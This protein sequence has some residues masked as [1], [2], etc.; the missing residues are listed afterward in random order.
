KLQDREPG[1]YEMEV[2]RGERLEVV[3][4]SLEI[5]N[6][7]A[8]LPW[9]FIYLGCSLS[10]F[11]VGMMMALARPESRMIQWG[12]AGCFLTAALMLG[13]ALH[14]LGGIRH[15]FTVMALES[16]FPLFYIAGYLFFDSF[17]EPVSGSSRWKM[18]F[19]AVAGLGIALWVPRTT[20]N[21]LRAMGPQ[22]AMEFLDRHWKLLHFYYAALEPAEVLYAAGAALTILAVL[23][24]NYVLLP[25]GSGRRRIR[26]VVWSN[27]LALAPVMLGGVAK[28]VGYL[29]AA[30]GDTAAALDLTA[31]LANGFTI[32]APIGLGYAVLKHRILGFG[33]VLR[34]GLSYMLARNVLRAMLLLPLA[35]IAFTV[36]TNPD[37]TLG[38]LLFNGWSRLNL[39][40]L[41]AGALG[42]RYGTTLSTAIDKRFFR[43]AYDQQQ[44]LL[45]LI[46]AIQQ[47][48][49]LAQIAEMAASQIDAALHVP[50]VTVLYRSPE[51]QGF[52]VS[53]SS[54]NEARPLRLEESSPM[55][56]E[57]RQSPAART[58]KELA[59]VSTPDETAWLTRLGVDL[60][61]PVQGVERNSLVGLL[62]VGEKRSEEPFTSKDKSLLQ[63]LAAQIGSVYE[64]LTLRGEIG[65]Q[66]R[67]QQEVLARFD[68]QQLNLVKECRACGA[69]YDGSAERC[70]KDDQELVIEVPVERVVEGKYRLERVIGR[71]GMG[72]VFEA[73]DLRLNRR[74]ALK[75]MVGHL[76][77]SGA[78]LRRFA[79]EAQA[80]ARL[81][82][83]NI[84]RVYDYGPLG[85][86][87]AYLV[88]EHVPGVTWADEID[89]LGAFPVPLAAE[90]LDQVLDGVE[91]AHAAG[92]LHR[93]LKPSNLMLWRPTE[94]GPLQVKILDFGLAKVRELT[95]A[96]PKS[97]TAE[98]VTLGTIG[99]MA[100]EQLLGEEVDER[101]DVYS[102]G[103]I[104]LETLTGRLRITQ[105]FFHR[106]IEAEL[107]ARLVVPARTE[108]QRAL[109][110]ALQGSLAPAR[111]ARTASVR[112][113]RG[114]LIPAI[115]R[116]E[117][118]PLPPP[119]GE[120]AGSSNGIP[121]KR[122][123][124]LPS[125]EPTLNRTHS[126]SGK[127]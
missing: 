11:T 93:D 13:E 110:G 18:V 56:R 35:W 33:L 106:T 45:S 124:S 75:V 57:L 59:I 3:P 9:I 107:A 121:A 103:V 77:G 85:E 98:G 101:A 29:L 27:T 90:A 100:P 48:D 22:T 34:M 61:V 47:S 6:D 74:V 7:P 1:A 68:R 119:P 80:S 54:G 5:R 94:G 4:L 69:C 51:G 8:F 89:R 105:Q 12:F 83:P 30:S 36:V 115:R 52:S 32:L 91:A 43:E 82:H 72:A 88:M 92:I 28:G 104:A 41:A 62:M 109:A 118:L 42:L 67:I 14:A 81:D 114:V 31:K 24:R 53:Y 120:L 79:R 55:L 76:I 17:P 16:A 102:L 99:Y 113:M 125:E 71:G 66:R 49:S 25:E 87:S 122:I 39:A 70:E 84:V 26:F 40:V 108:S 112:E 58:A 21:L 111:D 73:T 65:R 2:R 86:D 46:E 19:Y 60:V 37:R 97:L 116:C 117:E 123:P 64:V 50:R 127:V 15:D 38:E 95:F 63:L 96:D 23:R 126:R 78:A 44:I 20:L 10:F